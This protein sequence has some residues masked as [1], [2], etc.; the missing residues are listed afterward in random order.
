MTRLDAA[1]GETAL[2]VLGGDAWFE[3]AMRE[4]RR[5][6][7]R[8][9]AQGDDWDT[10]SQAVDTALQACRIG[11]RNAYLSALAAHVG[12]E[13]AEDVLSSLESEPI[14][15]YLRATHSMG[16]ELEWALRCLRDRIRG[17]PL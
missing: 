14:R 17:A 1:L 13:L 3:R 9:S 6:V 8:E 5:E 4:V 12:A 10:R 2:R 7:E 16:P 15:V 11:V